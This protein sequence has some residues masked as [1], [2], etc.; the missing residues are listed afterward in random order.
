MKQREVFPEEL[1]ELFETQ[2]EHSFPFNEIAYGP[3][4][5]D[6]DSYWS[7]RVSKGVGILTCS[8]RD[9]FG[10]A[11]DFEWELIPR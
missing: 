7:F 10:N 9:C 2:V 4:D 11:E 6:Y 1:L 3:E 8:L 5:T